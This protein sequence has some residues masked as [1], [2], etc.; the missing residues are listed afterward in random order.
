MIDEAHIGVRRFVVC[1]S[2]ALFFFLFSHVII[3]SAAVPTLVQGK[4]LFEFRSEQ[5]G[6]KGKSRRYMFSSIFH[7]SIAP[8]RPNV[9]KGHRSRVRN[10]HKHT[11]DKYVPHQ[12]GAPFFP[13]CRL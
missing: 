4:H 8:T 10:L 7:V 2:P 1:F 5:K 11:Y 12:K 13:V 3:C 9:N 6:K